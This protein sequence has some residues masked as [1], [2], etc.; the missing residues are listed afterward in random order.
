MAT[1]DESRN[2]SC[3]TLVSGHVFRRAAEYSL[4]TKAALAAEFVPG[5]HAR[6]VLNPIWPIVTSVT[7]LFF[8]KNQ[9]TGDGNSSSHSGFEVDELP[10]GLK[11]VFMLRF[12]GTSEDVP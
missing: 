9:D 10:Q 12:I 4:K 7:S 11:P 5:N 1:T 2:N 8:R 3:Q 6:S